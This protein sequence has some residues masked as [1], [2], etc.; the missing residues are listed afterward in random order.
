MR[1]Y[2]ES[3]NQATVLISGFKSNTERVAKRG[4]MSENITEFETF[5]EELKIANNEQEA[6]KAKLKTKTVEVNQKQD[7][8]NRKIDEGKKVVKLEFDQSEWKEFGIDDK[9]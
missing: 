5:L 8:V 4:I 9:R 7:R 3:V 6:I 2:A 1:T